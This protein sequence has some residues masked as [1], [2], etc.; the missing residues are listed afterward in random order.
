M[1]IFNLRGMTHA[2]SR[3][4]LAK[5]YVRGYEKDLVNVSD[6]PKLAY[7]QAYFQYP[8]VTCFA[9]ATD[10]GKSEQIK[11][12]L[13]NN[14]LNR[15]SCMLS[16]DLLERLPLT[17]LIHNDSAAAH[18]VDL[19]ADKSNHQQ[20][21]H[22]VLENNAHYAINP[23]DT[24]MGVDTPTHFNKPQMVE[25]LR[26]F[27]KP[28]PFIPHS[29]VFKALL[30]DLIKRVFELVMG[31]NATHPKMYAVG[32]DDELDAIIN[33]YKIIDHHLKE[34]AFT[35]TEIARKLH[36]AAGAYPLGSPSSDRLSK[37]RDIAYSLSVPILADLHLALDAPDICAK[38]TALS[39][40]GQPVLEAVRDSL[41]ANIENYPCFSNPTRIKFGNAQAVAINLK[42]VL[43]EDCVNNTLFLISAHAL[44]IKRVNITHA[45]LIHYQNCGDFRDYLAFYKRQILT[46]QD[47]GAV[48]AF[49]NIS[50]EKEV[51]ISHLLS[52]DSR[53]RKKLNLE[54]VLGVDGIDELAEDKNYLPPIGYIEKLYLFSKPTS[55]QTW[56]FK[57][58]F[59][60]STEVLGDIA[61]I[62]DTNYF[63]YLKPR[64]N[65][66]TS[67]VKT[68]LHRK[69]RPPV[70]NPS[71]PWWEKWQ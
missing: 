28:K 62:D 32:V 52:M 46:R 8:A 50:L 41:N 70:S 42:N 30:D 4:L 6:D 44:A 67:V 64:I 61:L 57:K 9:G 23:F 60:T 14:C 20:S 43:N 5:T 39:S 54:I 40:C 47:T 11:T 68:E 25:F 19:I 56:L 13:F 22:V 59:T 69:P 1:S 7:P 65:P 58:F 3:I 29:F 37:G 17:T 24:M 21:M 63:S 31:E 27:L 10:S 45:D 55:Y 16:P 34:I 53:E 71:A 38:H 2:G 36:L 12:H 33:D 66:T 35:N 48:I 26:V 51:G 49:D 18:F 15:T